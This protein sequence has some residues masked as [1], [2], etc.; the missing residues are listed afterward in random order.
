MEILDKII[1]I[2]FPEYQYYKVP[3]EKNQVVLHHTVSG[4]SA[5]AVATYWESTPSRVATALVIDKEGIPYQL[6]G[7]QYYAGHIGNVTDEF[8]D[9]DLPYRNCSKHSIGVEIINWGGLTMKEGILYNWYG[10]VFKGNATYYKKGYR[11]YYYFDTYTKE[12]IQ[13]VKELLGYWKDRYSIP[14]D[15][16]SYIWD[17][18]EP[19]LA[20]IPGVY[21]HTSFRE[22][23]SDV[24]PQRNLIEMLK[25]I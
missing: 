24:H 6:F 20:G 13:T 2:D 12:Q 11:G 14:M 9:F 22:D 18:N 1:Q 25:S 21:T 19:A 17:V 4:G 10:D 23:K 16:R 3:Y 7:S 5:Q 15:Y 8:G